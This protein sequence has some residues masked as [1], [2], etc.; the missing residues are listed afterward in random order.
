MP[1]FSYAKITKLVVHFAGNKAREEGTE[2]SANVLQDIGSEMN[3]TLA[4]IF[5]EPFTKDDYYQFSH[6]KIWILMRSGLLQ[7]ICSRRKKS[8]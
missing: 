5:L 1:D 4:S 2:V 6:E 8:F 3:Q 7:Q